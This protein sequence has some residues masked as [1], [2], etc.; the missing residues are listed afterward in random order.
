MAKLQVRPD[1]PVFSPRLFGEILRKKRYEAGFSS[2]DSFIKAISEQTGVYIDKE[3][4][5]RMERGQVE[6][7]ISKLIAICEVLANSGA[8]EEAYGGD[9]MAMLLTYAKP[10]SFLYNSD[11]LVRRRVDNQGKTTE[12]LTPEEIAEVRTAVM[13]YRYMITST[14][15]EKSYDYEY[16]NAEFLT[17]SLQW[18]INSYEELHN[19]I[20][21]FVIGAKKALEESEDIT[22]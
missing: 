4:M 22:F 1:T 14:D 13:N 7:S 21:P 18:F 2:A 20:E 16:G 19:A 6:P 8:Y 10:I 3:T 12:E 5:L 11:F 9:I 17:K 15:A